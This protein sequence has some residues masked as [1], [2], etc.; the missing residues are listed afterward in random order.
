MLIELGKVLKLKV[1]KKTDF[2][3]YLGGSARED[4]V[5]L[6]KKQV[7][8]GTNVGDELEVFIYK[9]SSDRLISTIRIP[10]L[11][12]GEVERLRIKEITKIG[13]FAEWGLEKDLFIP[14]REQTCQVVPGESYLV[15]LYID[16]SE[17]LAGTM[18]VYNYMQTTDLYKE[19][20][21]V[22]GTIYEIKELGAF[23]AVD[24]KYFGLIPAKEVHS[25]L[26]VGNVIKSRVTKVR[27]DGKLD[28]SAVKPAYLQ[29]G[30][31]VVK[32]LEILENLP[33][34]R[35]PYNDKAPAEVIDRDFGMSKSAFKR[36]IG[37]LY[38]ERKVDILE[39]SIILLK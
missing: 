6:P 1:V 22:A 23:V 33:D 31:D 2:G 39:D 38:K 24:N 18:R 4:R 34:Q 30:D 37:R 21:E 27:E 28:L 15:A 8:A 20:D 3:I 26:K 14:F 9:D 17:R 11:G 12:L 35:L 32:I 19:G 10:Y 16:K 7:P 5:L 25:N 13:A 36:A 29:M